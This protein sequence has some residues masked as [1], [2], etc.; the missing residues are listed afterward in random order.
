MPR[1]F[2]SDR[3][4]TGR[5]RRDLAPVLKRYERVSFTKDAVRPLNKPGLA[6][7]PM[8]HPGHPLMLAVSNLILEQ[9]S[10]LLRQ[11]AILLDPADESNEPHLLFMLTHEIK[12]G[13]D[14]VISKRLQ[15]VRVAPDGD[16]CRV[17]API[18]TWI[19]WRRQ[20]WRYSALC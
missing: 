17:G 15:F 5:N 8:L 12:A 2:A 4:I 13:N 18:S 1:P 11:G 9:H 19:R 14:Q 16:L 7:A 20:T 6:F 10:N 3:R